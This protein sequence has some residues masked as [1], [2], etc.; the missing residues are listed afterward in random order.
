VE[1]VEATSVFAGFS[2]ADRDSTAS[3]FA[4]MRICDAAPAVCT[5][6]L[7]VVPAG[8]STPV[9]IPLTVVETTNAPILIVQGQQPSSGVFGTFVMQQGGSALATQSLVLSATDS[10]VAYSVQYTS[11]HGWLFVTPQTNGSTPVNLTINVAPARL[12][13]GTYSGSFTIASSSLPN[14]DRKSVV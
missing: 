9:N 5:G 14:I 2:L 4:A 8:S 7:A 1:S 3:R 13:A 6:T 11:D 12:P 10:S